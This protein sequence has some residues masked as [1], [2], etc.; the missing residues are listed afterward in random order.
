MASVAPVSGTA[1]RCP[2]RPM[3]ASA[4]ASPTTAVMIGIPIAIRLPSTRVRMNIAQRM[5]T[6][7]LLSV[8]W[9]DSSVPIDPA[10]S[11]WM[12]ADDAGSVA[13]K[14]LLAIAS[15]RSADP[16]SSSTGAN[17][18]FLSSESS[19][20]VWPELLSGLVTL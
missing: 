12:P 11:T 16:T 8:A 20:A 7:S 15:S 13:S 2:I 17:A 19:P 14:T 3:L 9:S 18:V 10:A 4:N 1:I 5:P 6:T